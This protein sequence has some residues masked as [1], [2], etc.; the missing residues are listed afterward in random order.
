MLNPLATMAYKDL[1]DFI[2]ALDHAGE[3][4]RIP[5]EVDP[6]LEVAEIT[7]RVSKKVGPALLFERVKGS[8]MPLLINA[9][10]S[11]PRMRL[12]LGVDSLDEIA[13][14]LS[15]ILDQKTPESFLEKLKQLPKLL[16]LG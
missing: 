2:A 7:D 8:S 6:I 13:D 16:D 11:H 15:A 5:V 9:L 12:A 3:L 14:R 4:R 1:C 10:G